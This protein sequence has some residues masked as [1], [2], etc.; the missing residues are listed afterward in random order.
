[1]AETTKNQIDALGV[2]GSVTR[3]GDHGYDEERTGFQL[4]DPHQPEV[5][6]GA[7]SADDVRTAVEFAAA[8]GSRVAVQAT[9]H[10]QN[11]A[12]DG[13]V[14][15]STR[16]MSGV[17]VDPA[18]R[19]AWI[20]AGATW[21]QV[22][23][24]TAPHGLAP[25]SGS[26][27]GVGAVSY[28]LGG[29]VGLLARKYGFA[30]DHVRRIDLVTADGKLREVTGASDPDL[31]WA[32]RGGGG[33]FGVVTGMEIDLVPVSRIYG[34]GLF[35]DADEVP[36]ILAGWH[37]WT[38]DLPD[39]M[40]AAVAMLP[41]PDLPMVPEPLRGKHIAQVQIAY[42]GSPED[43]ERLL[44][45]VR[46]LGPTVRDTVREVPFTESGA[47]FDEP[48]RPHAYRSANLLVR[49]L[50]P[51]L[52]TTLTKAA[53][54]SAP[55]MC[56][57]GLRHLG[58]ALARSPKIPN[59]V[60]HRDAG[61]SLSVLSPVEPGERESVRALHRDLLAPWSANAMGRSLNFTFDEL[62]GAEIAAAFAPGDYRRLTEIRARHD[63]R[64]MFHVNHPISVP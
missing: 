3:P 29:G 22:I 64:A 27:P 13:G 55:V 23:E 16:R 35:F 60:G 1:M 6:V 59:A 40:T 24:A 20:E 49:D 26:F 48:D 62:G 54:P 15:I 4:L 61:Y 38:R 30:A 51:D 33:N 2:T 7:E 58:G 52:L 17:E 36:E 19:T 18:A 37:R 25:L 57:V 34:G 44:E 42:A 5:L 28:T 14:L 31:F 21:H 9:G 63:P 45:P 47:V 46:A 56:V 41:F 32:L 10:G 11:R 12:L 43:G 50:D 39:E 8:R 53:G